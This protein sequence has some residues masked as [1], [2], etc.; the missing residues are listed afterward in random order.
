M[1][2]KPKYT[3]TLPDG[4]VVTR[5]TVRTYTHVVVCQQKAGP[6]YVLNWC[7]RKDLA[8]KA[9]SQAI[10]RHYPSPTILEVPQP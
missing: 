1:P 2:K 5:D 9:L 8:D 10:A 4:Q 7:G 3:V 6:C